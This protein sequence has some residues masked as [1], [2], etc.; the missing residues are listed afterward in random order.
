ME[1]NSVKGNGKVIGAA[2]LSA[3]NVVFAVYQINSNSVSPI[4]KA[5][6]DGQRMIDGADTCIDSVYTHFLMGAG[7]REYD[8]ARSVW[9]PAC[10]TDGTTFD[11]TNARF[12][13]KIPKRGIGINDC[14]ATGYR[15]S[16]SLDFGNPL[17]D[18]LVPVMGNLENLKAVHGEA[19]GVD[20]PGTGYG[21]TKVIYYSE[22]GHHFALKS[23]G[24]H[25]L[26]PANTRNPLEIRLINFLCDKM[27]LPE[28]KMPHY[29]AVVSG[30]GLCN[31]FDFFRGMMGPHERTHFEDELAEF[32]SKQSNNEKSAFIAAMAKKHPTS[33]FGSTMKYEW[34]VVGRH[35]YDTAV[36]GTTWGG[37]WIAGGWIRK[38]LPLDGQ[39][40]NP[41]VVDSLR[42]GYNAGPSHRGKVDVVPI[43]AVLNP[44]TGLEGAL[45]VAVRDVY[46]EHEKA[47]IEKRA[48]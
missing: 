39:E 27:K 24:G 20:A 13:G 47:R 34:E 36:D 44:E 23:E 5:K 40:L 16:E 2:D 8:I 45:A 18:F 48:S 22:K 26:L 30:K 42:E 33:A 21:K 29:E 7:L 28:D 10:D 46:W 6:Y 41:L 14:L 4:Y 25:T 9:A 38:D 32:D 12:S 43:H 1:R 37:L 3:T 31:V 15:I 19:L 11:M 35:L 17:Q